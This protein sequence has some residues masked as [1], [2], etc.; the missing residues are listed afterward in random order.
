MNISSFFI[1]R[2]VATA[3]I[4][5][6][7]ALAGLI[8]FNLLPVASLP[9]VDF[10]TISVSARLPGASPETM[11][12]TVATPLERSLGRI[13]GITEMTSQSSLGSTRI[14]LQFDLDRDIDGAARDVQAAINGARSLLP[15]G[16]P[17]NPTYRKVNPADAPIL[18]L[19]LTSET[20]TRSQLYDAASTILAQKLSQ[21]K[22]VGQVNVGGGSLPAV[23]VELN[24][25]AL[26]RYGV[27]PEQVRLAIAASNA[28][29]PKGSL[30][31]GEKH[32]QIYANDQ[33]KKAE[34]YMPLIVSY[35][36]GAAVRLSDLGEV[37]DSNQDIRNAG[38][39]NGKPGVLLVISKQPGANVIET[40]DR[41][42]DLLPQLRASISS[43]INLQIASDRT[44][45]I[46]SSLV[47]VERTLII[48]IFLVIGVV[49]L[50][51]RN[52]P[53]TLIPSV[54]VPVSLA[55]T[56]GIMYLAGYTLDNL[57]L[58]ALTVATGFVVDDAIVVLENISRHIEAGMK[59]LAAALIGAKEVGFTVLSMSLSLIAV[60]I[61][62]LLMGGV[63]GRLFREFAVTLSAAIAVSLAVSL[64]TTPMM[65]ARLLRAKDELKQNRLYMKTERVFE[66]IL[67]FYRR[68]LHWALAHGRVMMLILLIVI[69]LNVFLYVVIPKGF[70]PQQD[71]GAMVGTIQAD[72]NISFQAMQSKLINIMTIVRSD[73]AV[74]NV[75][76]F[77]GG[78]QR[79][80]GFMYIS[81]KPFNKR[82]IS[83]DRVIARLR[84]KLAREPGARLF[85]QS[86]Q[87]IRVG[88]RAGGGMYQYTLQAEDLNE[89]RFWEKRLRKAFNDLPQLADVNTDEQD[90][91]LQTFINIDRDTASRLGITPVLI[92]STLNDYFGQRQV[93]TIYNPLNQYRVVM[94]AAPPYW[95]SPDSLKDIYVT[96]PA[97]TRYPNGTQVPL[98]SFANFELSN[99]PL[100]VNHQGQFPASTVSF[101]LPLGVSLSKA[102]E[103]IEK[104]MI[105][106]GV[107]SSVRGSFQG[108]ARTFQESSN[109]QLWLILAALVTI[110]IVL[111]I[112]YESYVHPVTILSTLPSAGVGALL[113]LLLFRVEFSIMSLIGVILLIGIVKKNAIMMIDF[114]LDRERN[115]GKSPAESIFEACIMRFRPIM[116][117]TTAA[118]FG[119]MPLIILT[120]E[121]SELR[122]PLGISI[123]G[124]LIVSQ[125]LTLYTT[126][127]VYLYLDRFRLFCLSILRRKKQMP[128][129]V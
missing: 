96:L 118:I 40:V 55:G 59:P 35:R 39:F 48:S 34:E 10:P 78:G 126:P 17:D 38:F 65:C 44:P 83:A 11:A 2:R 51:L 13:A 94:E 7:I 79:N 12:S 113:A 32:W 85:L 42:K 43:A 3:L 93:S 19:G 28:N 109:N 104:T 75:T 107:P 91:G 52:V 22:G 115:E 114:A 110:Y 125:I 61:P 88:G 37:V 112:L 14:T 49:F 69:C 67:E 84:P 27:S 23:R 101:N 76:G 30:E 56:F 15:S 99:T 100:A 62:I 16:M 1:H 20:M 80:S 29:R 46:R 8:A 74:E 72:Q 117:T 26:N 121:G 33:A 71:T 120:G 53:S 77:T 54:A 108:T 87:D 111:G 41:I 6:G 90:R 123:V 70:F 25:A 66:I 73:P 36:N 103:A 5:M 24:P 50:F 98:L 63:V 89:L 116:M 97:N 129:A 81:L 119:A 58:M 122:R 86:V 31:A 92:D 102:T 47:E 124:G 64:T 60:F 82:K 106:L 127:V 128:E 18:I 21:V 105:G 9:Q 45:S 4:T 57:S 68:T 95:Q